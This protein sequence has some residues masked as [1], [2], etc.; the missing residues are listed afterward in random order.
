MEEEKFLKGKEGKEETIELEMKKDVE[1]LKGSDEPQLETAAATKPRRNWNWTFG[2]NINTANRD[3]SGL[4]DHLAFDFTSVIAEPDATQSLAGI[5]K[6]SHIV[7]T[8]VRLWIY[9]IVTI[10]LGLPLALIWGLIFSIIALLNMWIIM[11]S[12]RVFQVGFAVV[13]KFVRLVM[14]SLADPVFESIGRVFYHIRYRR[15]IDI[16]PV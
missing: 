1:E 8:F 7:F 10:L 4:N 6:A 3:E 2:E 13:E 14:T 11:P 15:N 5:Y 12:L 9:K 16:N